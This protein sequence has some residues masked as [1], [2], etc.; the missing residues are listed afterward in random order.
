MLDRGPGKRGAKACENGLENQR[1]VVGMGVRFYG[2][3]VLTKRNL[4][5]GG[6]RKERGYFSFVIVHFQLL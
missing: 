6:R 5:S 3:L 1:V 4:V 2:G